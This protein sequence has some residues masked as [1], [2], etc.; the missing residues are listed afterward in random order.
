MKSE[1]EIKELL[2]Q[3]LLQLRKTE[4]K[5]NYYYCLLD[6]GKSNEEYEKKYKIYSYHNRLIAPKVDILKFI[7]E[8]QSVDDEHLDRLHI[9]TI[10]SK[11]NR[12]FSF[13]DD[14]R[15]KIDDYICRTYNYS[16]IYEQLK[17]YAQ[18]KTDYDLIKL[19][20]DLEENGTLNEIGG[21][22]FINDLFYEMK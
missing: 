10:L 9:L 3:Y 12:L 16:V 6:E 5:E 2:K 14:E 20:D 15:F 11:Y 22:R 13:S 18:T 17:A 7:L 21:R 4:E 1:K 8:L 19:C